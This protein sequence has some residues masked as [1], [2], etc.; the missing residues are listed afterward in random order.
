MTDY[1]KL[2]DLTL[3]PPSRSGSP[4]SDGKPRCSRS[5]APSEDS[6]GPLACSSFGGPPTCLGR[7]LFHCVTPTSIPVTDAP[8]PAVT[9]CLTPT[10]SLWWHWTYWSD[11]GKSPHFKILR[12]V[13]CVKSVWLCK[14]V[15]S[16]A[17]QIRACHLWE[18]LFSQLQ[19]VNIFSLIIKWCPEKTTGLYGSYHRWWLGK[20]QT[21]LC[22]FTLKSVPLLLFHIFVLLFL[23]GVLG[24]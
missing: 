17:P 19:I 2:N 6:G 20:S 1:H 4:K 5:C 13:T 8:T 10:R 9:S 24:L 16:H 21:Y 23:D 14:V 12:S 18:S 11:P 22:T 7:Q 15:S 3:L